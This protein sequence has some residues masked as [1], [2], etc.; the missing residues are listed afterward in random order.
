M[1]KCTFM[2]SDMIYLV[3]VDAKI[4][5]VTNDKTIGE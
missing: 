4:I 2:K 5:A 3:Y 1:D